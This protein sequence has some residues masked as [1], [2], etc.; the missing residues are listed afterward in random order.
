MAT[1]RVL[2]AN[3]DEEQ[4]VTFLELIFETARRGTSPPTGQDGAMNPE[5][6]P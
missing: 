5:P 4:E 1:R 3:R 6:L 2:R